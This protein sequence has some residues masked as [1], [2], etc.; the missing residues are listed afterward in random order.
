MAHP[1]GS[2]V[3]G[4]MHISER[5]RLAGYFGQPPGENHPHV[6]YKTGKTLMIQY[7]CPENCPEYYQL[8]C[9]KHCCG[10]YPELSL[11]SLYAAV[12]RS[13]LRI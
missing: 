13:I 10:R 4:V 1:N 3:H 11:L 12:N 6:E 8:L 5:R 7:R 2:T 9:Q